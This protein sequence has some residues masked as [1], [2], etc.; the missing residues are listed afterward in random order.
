MGEC[1]LII[2][3][4]KEALLASGNGPYHPGMRF[5]ARLA[6]LVLLSV[7]ATAQNDLPAMKPIAGRGTPAHLAARGFM[8]GANIA[9]YLEVPPGEG[10]S[11]RH[12]IADL[13]L[14]RAQGF[15]HIRLPVGWHHY[16]GPA[17]GYKLSGEIFAKADEM[18]TNASALGLNVII[19]LHHFNEFTTDPAANRAWFLAI[20]RQVAAHYAEAPSG[21]AFEL[22]NEPKDAAT[23]ILL[24]PIYAQAI[25]E[26]RRTNPR[27]TIFAGPGRWNSP[28]ELVNLRLP[29]DDDNIIVT[30]HCYDPMMFTHQGAGWAG[31]D[32]QLTGIVFPGPP[33]VPL[34][35]DPS[36]NLNTRVL[37]WV[38]QYNTFP[39][40]GNP[41]SPRAFLS[42]IQKAKAWSEEFGRP[43]HF[44][45]F[46]A[47]TKADQASRARYYGAFREAL[48][49]AGIGWAIWDWK[50][51]F[52]YWDT[53]TQQPLPGMR[54]ALFPAR[55]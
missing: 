45:E 53:K 22:L 29:E 12:T 15:D 3:L 51:G 47:F 16:T 37:D 32:H 23:T 6:F 5:I 25:R 40:N 9:N 44:G 48:D 30:L 36:L 43:V 27:R 35:P 8:R 55:G 31:P 24:N 26:I 4:R 50:S 21:V 20:W 19:N 18:A 52:N 13:E 39:S 46:G 28:E 34:Q 41:S 2:C 42:K 7:T 54:K 11:T 38:Q 17:P 33:K 10:W 1:N 14:I 49:A